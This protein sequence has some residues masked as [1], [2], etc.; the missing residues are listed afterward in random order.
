MTDEMKRS[1]NQRMRYSSTFVR[2]EG[3]DGARKQ[4]V[5]IADPNK[6]VAVP[7][8]CSLV[9]LHVHSFITPF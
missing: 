6:G 7:T 8:N 9:K 4:T 5:V 1:L 2:K 3:D